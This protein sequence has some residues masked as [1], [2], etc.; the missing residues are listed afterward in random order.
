MLA[1][2]AK[3]SS[4]QSERESKK[5]KR[6]IAATDSRIDQ[7]VYGLYELNEQEVA[8]IEKSEASSKDV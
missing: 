8:V 6:Q 2:Q 3:L 5:L 4:T 1:L 7:I